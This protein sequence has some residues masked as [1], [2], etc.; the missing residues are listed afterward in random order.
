MLS[1]F[2]H[3]FVF[4]KTAFLFIK[5]NLHISDYFYITLEYKKMVSSE[6]TTL[7]RSPVRGYLRRP[8]PVC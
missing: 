3:W 4:L 2:F 5:A 7:T 6:H 8:P 1:S